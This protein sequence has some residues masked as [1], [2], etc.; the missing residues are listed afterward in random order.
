MIWNKSA[1]SDQS[2]CVEIAVGG[3][4][5]YI[6]D[7]KVPAP[8]AIDPDTVIEISRRDWE[9]FKGRIRNNFSD[10]SVSGLRVLFYGAR[11]IFIS[12]HTNGA[13]FF[14]LAEWEAF[15]R[16]VRLDNLTQFC[17]ER[18]LLTSSPQ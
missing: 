5:V 12:P 16:G 9:E 3:N 14:T 17:H 2:N 11:T 18:E 7:S 6:R 8:T 13:L 10:V 1:Y 4:S 15:V